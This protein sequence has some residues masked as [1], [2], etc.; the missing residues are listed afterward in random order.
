MLITFSTKTGPTVSYFES[1]AKTLI[2]RMGHSEVIPGAILA[3]DLAGY[4]D[5]L[6]RAMQSEEEAKQNDEQDTDFIDEPVSLKQRAKPLM[7]LM[8]AAIERGE[9]LMWDYD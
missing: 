6:S 4:L 5:K 8:Q 9:N 2:K 7:E 1:I 3:S